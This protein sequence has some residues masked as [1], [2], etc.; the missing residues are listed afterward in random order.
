VVPSV[1]WKRKF[2]SLGASVEK[3]IPIPLLVDVRSESDYNLFHLVDA[4]R[5]DL[6]AL[7]ADPGRAL[8]GKD[9]ETAIKVV[10]A[11]DDTGADEAYRVLRAQGVKHV[12]VLA[13]GIDKWLEAFETSGES[14]GVEAL[15]D[16][17]P[18]SRPQLPIFKAM[19]KAAGENPA[20]KVVPV[21]EAPKASGGCG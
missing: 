18:A 11:K 2:L 14:V 10:M 7:R 20:W 6:A 5:T 4:H 1:V 9:W 21:V 17:F 16:R 15:G 12:Y 13:G 8:A 19:L 3:E